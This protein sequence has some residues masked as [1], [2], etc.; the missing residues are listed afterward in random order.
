MQTTPV[1]RAVIA[2]GNAKLGKFLPSYGRVRAAVKKKKIRTLG[3]LSQEARS[4]SSTLAPPAS[5]SRA[6]THKKREEKESKMSQTHL[7][8]LLRH[9]K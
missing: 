7:T 3:C 8:A 5:S 4:D 1:W 2:I 9:L 6:G